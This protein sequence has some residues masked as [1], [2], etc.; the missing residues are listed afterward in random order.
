MKLLSPTRLFVIPF[1]I[2]SLALVACG[3]GGG[4]GGG[5]GDDVDFVGGV[6]RGEMTMSSNPC[7][8][9]VDA[10][11]VA[12][13]DVNQAGTDIVL[14]AQNGTG[15]TY[16]G[17]T[18]GEVILCSKTS[19]TDDGCTLVSRIRIQDITASSGNAIFQL[20]AN[21]GRGVC[22]VQYLGTLARTSH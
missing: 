20:D 4:G 14:T 5:G 3:G 19:V 13:W 15:N 2:L 9:P 22:S 16:E 10:S 7:A 18:D 11:Q 12:A 21:C 17:T 6:Y 8:I 1:A